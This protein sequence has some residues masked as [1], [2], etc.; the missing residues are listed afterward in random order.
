[1]SVPVFLLIAALALLQLVCQLCGVFC[2]GVFLAGALLPLGVCAWT[3]LEGFVPAPSGQGDVFLHGT[4]TTDSFSTLQKTW[5]SHVVQ[6]TVP[7]L[8]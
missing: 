3:L 6:G 1:M 8:T 4:P 5:Q 7:L 2:P